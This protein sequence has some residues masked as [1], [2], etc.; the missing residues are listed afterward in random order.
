[1]KTKKKQGYVIPVMPTPYDIP[2]PEEQECH[3]GDWNYRILKRK[4]DKQYAYGIYEVY[5]HDETG[6]AISCTEEP[7]VN[8]G[9]SLVE[10]YGEMDRMQQALER[11]ILDYD[12]IER[13]GL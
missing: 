10:L 5:Y 3:I 12:D 9:N 4:Y 1:M 6:E 8:G 11:E 7:V 2:K 13:K